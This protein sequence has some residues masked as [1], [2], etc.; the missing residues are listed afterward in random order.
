[1]PNALRLYI[2]MSKNIIICFFCLHCHYRII[3]MNIAHESSFILKYK[4]TYVLFYTSCH[5]HIEPHHSTITHQVVIIIINV[6]SNFQLKNLNSVAE[7]QIKHFIII[8]IS[9]TELGFCQ[10]F[11]KRKKN[12]NSVLQK[13]NQLY[14]V[15]YLDRYLF[16]LL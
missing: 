13:I 12:L 2:Y 1:M 8:I 6:L 7:N 16:L 15:K 11:L 9:A 3:M 14:A 10:P 4:N 5:I